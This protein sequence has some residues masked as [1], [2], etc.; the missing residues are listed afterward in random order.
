MPL[1]AALAPAVAASMATAAGDGSR[2]F[3]FDDASA[4]LTSD[5]GPGSG[6]NLYSYDTSTGALTDLT[7]GPNPGVVGV[8]NEASQDG[9]YLYFVAN[10]VLTE[11]PNSLGQTASPGNCEFLVALERSCNLYLSHDGAISFIHTLSGNAATAVVSKQFEPERHAASRVTPDGRHIAFFAEGG[12][13]GGGESETVFTELFEYSADSGQLS[14]LCAC[15]GSEFPGNSVGLLM[16]L[17]RPWA[18]FSTPA[19]SDDGARLLRELPGPASPRHEWQA[20]CLRV[21]AGRGEAARSPLA[22][23]I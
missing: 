13:G 10:G 4:G 15:A 14:H 23:C 21:R 17:T 3:F 1:R 16:G 8:A 20:R 2:V 18:C 11:A 5:T 7:P 19:L 22:A 6:R 12:G 9:S